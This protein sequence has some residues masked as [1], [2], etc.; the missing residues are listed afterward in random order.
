VD[1]ID[2]S[3][4]APGHTIIEDIDARSIAREGRGI[5]PLSVREA[6][7]SAPYTVSPDAD[8]LTAGRMILEYDVGGLP[9]VEQGRLVGMI[10]ATDL[11]GLLIDLL[12]VEE[13]DD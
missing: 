5:H 11:V 7:T 10:T 9:V 1:T 4:P 3:L 6:M 13:S 8:L 2:P 12:S